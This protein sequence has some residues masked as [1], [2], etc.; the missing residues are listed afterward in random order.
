M[1]V[2]PDASE[3][4]DGGTFSVSQSSFTHARNVPFTGAVPALDAATR[5]VNGRVAS[6]RTAASARG[7][8]F[9]SSKS[10]MRSVT[11]SCVST[12]GLNAHAASDRAAT[13]AATIPRLI[14]SLFSF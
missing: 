5:T 4:S 2:S 13:A 9:R 6:R 1:R 11:P 10:R 14:M 8:S 7:A 12:G 3:R